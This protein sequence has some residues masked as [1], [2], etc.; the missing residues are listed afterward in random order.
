[1]LIDRSE[2]KLKVRIS[3][4]ITLIFMNG[5]HHKYFL[6]QITSFY[7]IPPPTR[8]SVLLKNSFTVCFNIRLN[9]EIKR[10]SVFHKEK[11]MAIKTF[12]FV[13]LMTRIK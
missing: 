11:Q 7:K 6:I 8:M 4:Q 1:V 12:Y 3:E 5:K 13:N 10:I 2:C 9:S